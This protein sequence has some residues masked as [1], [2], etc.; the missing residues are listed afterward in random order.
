MDKSQ[1]NLKRIRALD[2]SKDPD[3]QHWKTINGSHVHLDGNGNY[4]G[5]AGSKFNGRHHY[6]PGWKQKASLMNRLAAALQAHECYQHVRDSW[7]EDKHPRDEDGR[8][9]SSGSNGKMYSGLEISLKK[10]GLIKP[11]HIVE[12]PKPIIVT[13]LTE[14]A[15]R[16]GV[17]KKMAQHY[18]DHA[19]VRIKQTPDK[20]EY[21]ADDGTVIAITPAG[22]VVSAWSKKDY[23]E[24][25]AAL[26]REVR[27]WITE[28]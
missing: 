9:T 15:K 24:R 4:D 3:P 19:F 27:K 20:Y 18:I 28:N 2:Y 16:H 17:T 7:E 13:S 11:G 25:H 12:G 10:S 6:G 1:V 23:D 22:R 14:H 8:F 26:V 5:G 21:I